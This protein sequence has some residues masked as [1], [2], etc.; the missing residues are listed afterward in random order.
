[1][2]V[3]VK[4]LSHVPLFATPWTAA[5]QGSSVLG[6]L[7][8]RI[9]EWTAIPFLVPIK[10]HSLQLT[11]ISCRQTTVRQLSEHMVSDP[12][13]AEVKEELTLGREDWHWGVTRKNFF[14]DFCPRVGIIQI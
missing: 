3:K 14:N 11:A 1:M 13:S 9:L 5:F 6:I 7:Q 12:K 10:P 4:S 8:A 2:K